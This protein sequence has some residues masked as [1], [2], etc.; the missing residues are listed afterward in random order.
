MVDKS[1][2]CSFCG[3]NRNSVEKLIAGP[4]VYICNECIKVSY[5]ILE[6]E[7]L[8]SHS[9][10]FDRESLSTPSQIKDKLNEY[11][12]GHDQIKE[13]LSVSAYNHY[14]R[15]L[16]HTDI[17]IE[18]SNILLTGPT[19]T[20]KTLF[21]KTLSK[22]LDVPFVIADATSLTE[23]GYVGNDVE[24]ILESLIAKAD[25]DINLAQM[26]IIYIDEIDKKAK[27]H[28]IS[29]N[30]RDVSGEGVQQ[31]L[32][33]LIEGNTINV[34]MSQNKKYEETVEF[35]TSNVLFIVSGAFVGLD[36]VLS[37][38]INNSAGIGF[39]AK[40]TA[41]PHDVMPTSQDII[42]YG[43]IPELVGRLPIICSLQELSKQDLIEVL[44]DVKN[45]ILRQYIELFKLDGVELEFGTE[46]KEICADLAAKEKLGARA[47]RQIV[48]NTLQSLM[49]RLPDL[50]K[51]GVKKII[52]NKYPTADYLPELVFT[53]SVKSD[54]GYMSYRGLNG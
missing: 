43:I 47:L 26:G 33:K 44:S 8:N 28:D 2:S 23:S 9:K 21:A 17:E 24:S 39:G 10:Q 38:R 22:I 50:Q 12:V 35:D 36:K 40:L 52:I 49:F 4:N 19:G 29:N 48:E 41:Q 14:K 15:V 37:N 13:I 18:K 1:L 31:A 51:Q 3:K 25:Y 20:G 7:S 42:S 27:Q 53:D 16:S 30:A 34:R 46:Y 32:L 5:R 54:T 6:S 45:S 11:I